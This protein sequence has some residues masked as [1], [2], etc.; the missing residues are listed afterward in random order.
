MR[1]IDQLITTVRQQTD[2]LS[3][4][5][6]AGIQDDEY[7]Q[8][9]N[10]AQDRIYSLIQEEFPRVFVKEVEINVN[11]GQ[12]NYPIPVDCYLGS[13]VNRVEYS[14]SGRPE[15]YYNLKQ[16]ELWER[17]QF[18]TG[19]PYLYIRRGTELLI[20]PT[21]RAGGLLRVTYQYKLPR[22]DKRYGTVGTVVLGVDSITSLILDTTKVFDGDP[23]V[24]DGYLTV[25]NKDGVI[26]MKGIPVDAIDSSTGEVT[27][28]AGFTFT[29]GE[30]I[31]VGDFIVRGKNSTTNSLLPDEVESYFIEKCKGKIYRRDSS[32]DSQ[33]T[34]PEVSAIEQ[35]IV[36][37]YASPSAD[38]DRIPIISPDFL[39]SDWNY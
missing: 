37:S 18:E 13:R 4:T 27:V 9:F 29:S 34:S 19:L 7:I 16:V 20:Q 26:K 14:N 30:S 1:R 38:I 15:N 32:S 33:E 5:S 35:Q 36:S 17:D 21:P 12:Q 3:F 11:I 23:V 39:V 31:S 28:S 25:V 10:D 6:T 22:L 24:D 8:A 2:T